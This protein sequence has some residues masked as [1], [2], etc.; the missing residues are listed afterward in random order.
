MVGKEWQEL[1][2]ALSLQWR[3]D[4]QLG[5]GLGED[6]A[7]GFGKAPGRKGLEGTAERC[8][9]LRELVRMQKLTWPADV[10]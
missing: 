10:H 6:G 2:G 1:P 3:P 8:P 7:S 9:E 4:W 5:W